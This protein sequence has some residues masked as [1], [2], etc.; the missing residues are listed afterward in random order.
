M[1]ET[2]SIVALVVGILFGL[3]CFG[4][5]KISWLFTILHSSVFSTKKGFYDLYDMADDDV[6]YKWYTDHN[7]GIKKYADYLKLHAE[8]RSSAYTTFKETYDVLVKSF[9]TRILPIALAPA[10]L[11]WSNW[12]FYL[13]GIAVTFIVLVAYEVA[14][15]G[16]RPGF[17]Q[18]LVVYT[19]LSTYAKKKTKADQ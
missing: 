14:K 4:G 3:W 9:L 16:V 6:S 8:A 15:N 17:Y 19:T 1:I 10:V 11:F 5:Q 13:I 7:R 12:Y 18:R 2:M